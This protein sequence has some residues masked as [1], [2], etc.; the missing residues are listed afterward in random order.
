MWLFSRF[1]SRTTGGDDGNRTHDPLLAGQV[2]SQLSYTPI[3]GVIKFSDVPPS[4]SSS[5]ALFALASSSLVVGTADNGHSKLNN[6]E[7]RT[8][9]LRLCSL[10]YLFGFGLYE[11]E[12]SMTRSLSLMFSIER[13]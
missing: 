1:P 10:A 13:R 7:S 4:T 12:R 8:S 3:S 6:N 5:G 11:Y 9:L 2:L